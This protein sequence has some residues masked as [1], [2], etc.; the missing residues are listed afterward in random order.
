[1]VCVRL[2]GSVGSKC[3]YWQL[4]GVS[5]IYGETRSEAVL[6][7]VLLSK[8]VLPHTLRFFLALCL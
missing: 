2:S 3:L 7:A 4:Y 1:M 8:G 6:R 5:L